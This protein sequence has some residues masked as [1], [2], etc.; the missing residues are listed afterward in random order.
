MGSPLPRAMRRQHVP[1]D[2]RHPAS[3][4]ANSSSKIVAAVARK[5]TILPLLAA[6]AAR[7]ALPTPARDLQATGMTIELA[8]LD[9]PPI[10]SRSSQQ[11]RARGVARRSVLTRLKLETATEHEAIEAVS[12]IMDPHLSLEEYRAYLE[13]TF[14]FYLVVE[15]QLRELG[16]WEA[17]G[18]PA[19]EREKLPLL[20][21]DIV[22]LGN[23]EPTS[24]RA[25][26]APPRFSSSAEAVGG[27]YVLEGSTL[28]GRVIFRHVRGLF[29]PD[30]ART[31][32]DCYG[33]DTREQ[34]QSF[35]SALERFASS[36][37]VED[38]II[39]GAKDT[40]RAF[41]R[42]LDR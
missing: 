10:S 40:F 42:W 15:Q 9:S 3:T 4:I 36:R 28:G 33:P 27:A 6:S 17:L 2:Q 11:L 1:N 7:T 41:T 16:V 5:P 22:L 26:D 8:H 23:T 31:F 19:S 29:G 39:A 38:R 13:R 12:G 30:V 18:L 21:E 25:C 37:E 24:I 14:G 32:L 34:W 35:R 20:A